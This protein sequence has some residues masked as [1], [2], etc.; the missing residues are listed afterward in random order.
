VTRAISSVIVAI[1]LGII[2]LN[3]E[4]KLHQR[5]M[6]KPTIQRKRINCIIYPTNTRRESKE[7]LASRFW[8]QES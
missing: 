6:N 7:Y 3:V 2:A 4:G 8:S 1:S 5:Y